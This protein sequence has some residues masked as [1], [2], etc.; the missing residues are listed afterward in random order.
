MEMMIQTRQLFTLQAPDG[1]VAEVCVGLCRFLAAATE[2]VWQAD[3]EG[4]FDTA[5]AL[6]V[7]DPEGGRP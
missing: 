3:G 2:G 4:F 7:H 6:L 1:V 5:G